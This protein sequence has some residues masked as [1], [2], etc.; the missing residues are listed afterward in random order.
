MTERIKSKRE[1][2]EVKGSRRER[3]RSKY[4]NRTRSTGKRRGKS[5]NLKEWKIGIRLE[6]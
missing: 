3:K 4:E 2:G 6:I 5:K 1:V